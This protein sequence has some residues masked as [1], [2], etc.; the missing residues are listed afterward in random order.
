MN[1]KYFILISTV[2]IL[3]SGYIIVDKFIDFTHN[4]SNQY[5]S[6]V[7]APFIIPTST[8]LTNGYR[9]PPESPTNYTDNKD[10]TVTDNYTGLI[11]KKC[12]QGMSGSDCKYGSPSLREWSKARVECEN[13][14]F[15][16][17]NGWRL[18]N[19]KELQSIVDTG[20]FKPSINKK[21]FVSSDDP[22]WTL[23]SPAEYP[24]NK[25][26]VLFSDG[27]VYYNSSNNAAATRCV[28]DK[29][30]K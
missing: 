14:S 15:A 19:L 12:S 21:F 24:S 28:Y 7:I 6:V 17:K 1:N 20:S 4:S 11:W 26:T 22:Y 3:S 16:G 29:D 30:E 25:F 8:I 23:T 10:G 2:A 18:P 13:L 27:S 9:L 5:A